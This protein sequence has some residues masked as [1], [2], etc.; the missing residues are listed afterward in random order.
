VSF[1]KATSVTFRTQR[2]IREDIGVGAKDWESR[3]TNPGNLR[4]DPAVDDPAGNEEAKNRIFGERTSSA[5][6][7]KVTDNSFRYFGNSQNAAVPVR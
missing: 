6:W 5:V 4:G 2:T 3:P 7:N 1:C